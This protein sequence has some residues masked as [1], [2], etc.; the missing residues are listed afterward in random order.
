MLQDADMN[1]TRLSH[2]VAACLCLG[3]ALAMPTTRAADEFATAHDHADGNS[4][5]SY[6]FESAAIGQSDS[7]KPI[8]LAQNQ[9][10]NTSA[11]I[12]QIVIEY[13][14]NHAQEELD[15]IYALPIMAQLQGQPASMA[16]IETLNKALAV[17]MR[18][19]GFMVANAGLKQQVGN[20]GKLIVVVYEGTIE[21][22]EVSRS[23]T[24]Y[25]SELGNYLREQICDSAASDCRGYS[26]KTPSVQRAVGIVSDLPGIKSAKVLLKPGGEN[27]TTNVTL[28]AIETE[29][30]IAGY[31]AADNYGSRYTGRNR[32]T[33]GMLADNI[34]TY[35]DQFLAEVAATDERDNVTGQ[36]S[37]SLPIGYDGLRTGLRLARSQYLLGDYFADLDS[38]GTSD[39]ASVFAR[40]P[41]I[42]SKDHNLYLH[43]TYD[44]GQSRNHIL[45][46]RQPEARTSG[47]G[48]SMDG[49]LTDNLLGVSYN[50]YGLSLYGGR[51]KAKDDDYTGITGSYNTVNWN[52]S[53][54]QELFSVG[55]ARI[56]LYVGVR[57]QFASERL[58]GSRKMSLGGPTGVRGYQDGE[59][60]GDEAVIGTVELRYSH[61][62]QDVFSLGVPSFLTVGLVHDHGS[63]RDK[64]DDTVTDSN[65]RSIHSNGIYVSLSVDDK[66]SLSMT[67]AKR[68]S[69]RPTTEIDPSDSRFWLRGS[70]SF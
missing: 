33:L 3:L 60:S 45:G 55:G 12:R 5:A 59:G 24:Y 11:V 66:Y 67:W 18:E 17:H 7:A 51:I 2:S 64:T 46:V 42:R 49:R 37:Y 53:R 68:G 56:G 39:I 19:R 65:E 61:Y 36:L 30:N 16:N 50:S 54:D 69:S 70:A 10:A 62:I 52:M 4:A 6:A 13:V 20:D 47:V 26:L 29:R 58:D 40:Y 44:Y 1:N 28:N 25:N 21:N 35:A 32:L 57:G 38:K 43:A 14:G 15:G 9:A 41:L 8:L 34:L 31:L 48:L 63:R 23:A 22:L 27:G